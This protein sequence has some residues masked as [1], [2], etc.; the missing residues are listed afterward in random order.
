ML[1]SKY[2]LIALYVTAALA[3]AY[4]AYGVVK[5]RYILPGREN[6]QTQNGESPSQNGQ[7]GSQENAGQDAASPEGG[8]AAEETPAPEGT[9]LFVTNSDCDS[10]CDKFED[11]ADDLK[12]CQQVCGIIPAEPKSSEEECAGSEGIEKDYCWRDLAVSQKDITVCEKISDNKL[13]SV[14][15]NRVVEEILN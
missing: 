9:R 10:D 2:I 4:F 11:N 7:A 15:R 1:K 6:T 8:A 14:C 3:V 5:K 13:R 12:Y